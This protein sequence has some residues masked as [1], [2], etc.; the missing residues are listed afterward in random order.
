MKS[1]KLRRGMTALLSLSLTATLPGVQALSVVAQEAPPVPF[2][3]FDES[4]SDE[5]TNANS[6]QFEEMDP[7]EGFFTA[8]NRLNLREAVRF[9]TVLLNDA[10]DYAEEQKATENYGKLNLMVKKQ[11]DDALAAAKLVAANPGETE[12][13]M[14]AWEALL[15]AC[16]L[17]DFTADKTG[18]DALIKECD[19]IDPA[20]H[21]D[22][23]AW[24]AFEA[25]LTEAKEVLASETALDASIEAA[26]AKLTEA[27][28]NLENGEVVVVNKTL[29]E[30]A[31][32]YAKEADKTDVHPVVIEALN[33][34]VEEAE[35]V[36]GKENATQDEINAAW[37]KLVK[38][39]QYLDFKANKDALNAL[40]DECKAVDESK[41]EKDANWDAFQKAITDAEAVRDNEL[42]L[43]GSI[44]AAIVALNAAKAALTPAG[45]EVTEVNKSL[46]NVAIEEAKAAKN[47]ED[48]ATVNEVVKAKF[49][50]ALAEAEAVKAD[51]DATQA[52]VDA[53]WQN[54]VK[55]IQMLDFKSDKSGLEATIA[56]ADA[57][58][59]SQYEK[60]AA[61]DAFQEA[62]TAANTVKDDPYALQGRIDE[63]RLALEKA[64]AALNRIDKLDLSQLNTAIAKADNLDLDS[65][66]NTELKSAFVETL[67]KAK[68][69]A[70]APETQEQINETAVELSHAMI[71]I[72]LLSAKDRLENLK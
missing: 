65:F 51:A 17:L 2:T 21:A 19:A 34:A 13:V 50:E 10:I 62:L 61:W 33:K 53:A 55:M 66:R 71:Q 63:A 23:P 43:Q 15:N 28:G 72:R 4:S 12:E 49:E 30:K 9:D 26:V 58:D 29:L 22:D 54:L 5:G 69:V 47:A 64:M 67:A 70:A 68:A 32:K 52:E 35:A 41:Y 38:A 16:H 39:I 18:L 40:I 57:I 56:K 46:L 20:D 42:A 45:G 7:E 11:F 24:P 6:G 60:D 59:A 36:L 31:V 25:A 14:A 27:K 8:L 1:K 44:D 3:P 37:E 48:Y